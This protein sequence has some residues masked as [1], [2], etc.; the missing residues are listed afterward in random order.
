L[1][2]EEKVK[3]DEIVIDTKSKDVKDDKEKSIKI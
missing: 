2:K 3:I 1:L